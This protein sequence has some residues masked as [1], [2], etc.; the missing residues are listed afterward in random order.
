M[1]TVVVGIGNTLLTD[2][3]FGPRMIE[4]LQGDPGVPAAVKLIDGGTAVMNLL[5]EV[6]AADL[7]LVVDAVSTGRPPGTLVRV[8]DAEVPMLFGQVLSAHQNGVSDL[9]AALALTGELPRR[10]V[11]VGVEPGSL[12]TGCGLTPAVEQALPGAL[13]LVRQELREHGGRSAAPR[14]SRNELPVGSGGSEGREEERRS[15]RR[16]RS[17]RP[18]PSHRQRPAAAQMQRAGAG[19]REVHALRDDAHGPAC[20]PNGGKPAALAAPHGR[21]FFFRRRLCGKRQS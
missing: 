14:R 21:R 4:L 13:A 17:L 7:L 20:P 19:R 9:L 18:Q 16:D 1:D 3:G 8:A 11:V 6:A 10:I 5:A 2:D 12:A 15:C